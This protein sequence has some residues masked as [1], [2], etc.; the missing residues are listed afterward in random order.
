MK[1]RN[2]LAAAGRVAT[3]LCRPAPGHS[4]E[5]C[6]R[7]IQQED[8]GGWLLRRRTLSFVDESTL[9]RLGYVN[10]IPDVKE[11]LAEMDIIRRATYEVAKATKGGDRF[12]DDI[13]V[14]LDGKT[15]FISRSNPS[16]V[17]AI[18]LSSPDHRILW[19]FPIPGINAD[20]MGISPDGKHIAVSAT[21]DGHFFVIDTA[22]GKEVAKVPTGAFP[23]QND[24]LPDGKYIYNSSLGIIPCLTR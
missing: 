23:H 15:V 3:R 6:L 7:P 9:T 17:I 11:R 19:R 22:T 5:S 4:L 13:A 16:D 18:D 20:H 1:N 14:S 12:V 10:A 24:Y 8:S 21:S 2:H